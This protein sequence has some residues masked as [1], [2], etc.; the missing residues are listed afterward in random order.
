VCINP[1]H[2]APAQSQ[3]SLLLTALLDGLATLGALEDNIFLRALADLRSQADDDEMVFN[4]LT[5]CILHSHVRVIED[6]VAPP[7]KKPA[8]S[9]VTQ[10]HQDVG[11]LTVPLGAQLMFRSPSVS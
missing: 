2:Y 3:H 11:G 8:A 5:S 7:P 6:A 10:A 4:T 1:Y 9:Q